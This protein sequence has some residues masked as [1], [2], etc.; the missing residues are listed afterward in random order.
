MKNV[1][2][3]TGLAVLSTSAFA[4]KARL[5]ALGSS[6]IYYINDSRSA[7]L[8]P[9][10]LNGAKNLMV[11]EWGAASSAADSGIA[12]KAEGG[13]FREMGT[14]TYG[15][16]LGNNTNRVDQGRTTATFLNQ[17]NAIDLLLAG[18]MGMKWGARLHYASS[19]IETGTAATTKKNDAFGLSLGGKNGNAGAYINMD[20]S[21]KSTGNGTVGTYES[22]LKPSYNVGGTYD[23]SGFNFFADY[24]SS[25]LEETLAAL[26]TTKIST[27]LLG[28]GRIHEINPTSRF[29]SS[30]AFSSATGEATSGATTAKSTETSLPVSFGMEADATSWLVVRGSVSQNVI[31]GQEKVS[32]TGSP[33]TKSTIADSTTVST[34]ATLNFGKLKVDGLVGTTG[35]AGAPG[36]KTGVLSTNNLLTRVGVTYAF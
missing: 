34:G 17:D 2:L 18:D 27:L 12:P 19:K 24:S 11:T 4:S 25:K 3:I 10:D 29:F 7:F 9:A 15:L 1:L 5:E 32:L 30:V 14:F 8:N 22:K 20:L 31:I 36:S 13:F 26:T 21:D 16:Y 28:V 33:D 35:T 6:S 23:F